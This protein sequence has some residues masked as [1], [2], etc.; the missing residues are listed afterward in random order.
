M[1]V[2]ALE[3]TRLCAVR[4]RSRPP[5]AP[6]SVFPR[7]RVSL[8]RPVARWVGASVPG[9]TTSSPLASVSPHFRNCSPTPPQIPQSLLPL[10]Q[11]RHRS[12][13]RGG[14]I[15]GEGEVASAARRPV[16]GGHSRRRRGSQRR[17]ATRCG[18]RFLARGTIASG[19][20][21][22]QVRAEFTG[23]G[24]VASGARAP[25][26]SVAFPVPGRGEVGCAAAPLTVVGVQV[27]DRGGT[28]AAS[29]V[30]FAQRSGS[31]IG[32]PS[33]CFTIVW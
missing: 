13:R 23:K 5:G 4:S 8:G 30:P 2:S 27:V 25:G 11:I 24:E 20:C 17:A 15:H 26:A 12:S 22:L 9:P 21:G 28:A 16:A 14:A 33:P 10:P 32:R 31:R 1:L 7:S 18:R 19:A 6:L 29:A 3:R